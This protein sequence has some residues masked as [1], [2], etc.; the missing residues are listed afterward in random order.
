[1]RLLVISGS[2]RAGSYNTALARAA[3]DLAPAGVDVEVFDG[4]A[5]RGHRVARAPAFVQS[6]GHAHA[7][8]VIPGGFAS[9]ADP[10]AEGAP[11][12]F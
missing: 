5:K 1:M 9:A 12:G 3:V 7:I 4:L 6:M 8:E 2:L 11:A 10:R